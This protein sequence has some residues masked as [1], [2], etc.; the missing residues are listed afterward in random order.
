ME[1]YGWVYILARITRATV[2][3]IHSLGGGKHYAFR[4]FFRIPYSV[5]CVSIL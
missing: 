2:F 3:Q 5:G 1:V 4:S